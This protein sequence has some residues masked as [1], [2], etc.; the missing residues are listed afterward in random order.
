MAKAT[1]A[2][3]GALVLL[4]LT[5]PS[6]SASLIYDSSVVISGS[7]FGSIPR[8]LT[9]QQHGQG[10]LE[11][12]C[13]GNDGSGFGIG[14]AFCIGD[15]LVDAANG[16]ANVGGDEPT[17]L[18]FDGNKFAIPTLASLGITTAGQ[19]GLVFN[20]SD[21]ACGATDLTDLTLKFYSGNTLR[22]AIDGSQ[23]FDATDCGNGSAGF[24][25]R[26]SP[27]ALAYVNGLIAT[28]GT[29]LIIATEASAIGANGGPDSFFLYNLDAAT[30]PEP[31]G[32]L[33]L[34]TGFLSLA[35]ARRRKANR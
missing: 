21:P 11:S 35:A 19:I 28:Y 2:G 10:G 15:A 34:A 26:V 17:P 32:L 16:I 3:F 24:V 22:G 5:A 23:A 12:G 20:P 33:L 14:D 7:G 8:V 29:G 30:V 31:A 1:W 4:V 13:V 9:M 18:G 27:D 25:F 6:A